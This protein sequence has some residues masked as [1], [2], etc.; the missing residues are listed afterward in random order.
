MGVEIEL[1]ED[2]LGSIDFCTGAVTL[3]FNASF[4]AKLLNLPMGP[5]LEVITQLVTH[6]SSGMN[7]T[8]YGRAFDGQGDGFIVGVAVVPPTGDAL[9]DLMLS[10]PSDAVT[11]MP[12]N[13]AFAC[14]SWAQIKR[15]LCA[16][17]Q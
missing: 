14:R 16:S 15:E 13:L 11:Q 6:E 12:C 1:V 5:A 10:L 8:V 7:N 17:R 4:T 3:S 2:M 9:I